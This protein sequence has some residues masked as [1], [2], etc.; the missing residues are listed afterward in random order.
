MGSGRWDASSFAGSTG[1]RLAKGESGYAYSDTVT[2]TKPREEWKVHDTLDPKLENKAGPHAGENVRESCDSDEH[3]NSVPIVVLFDVTGSMRQ[4]PMELV[5]KLPGLFGLLQ[6]KGYVEDPQVLFGAI[7]DATCDQA[8]LQVSQ[9]ES[10][11]RMDDHLTNILLEGGGGAQKTE[12]YE[13]AAY[14]FARKTALDS[15]E[16][17]G[18]KGYLF[19]I[20]DEMPYPQVKT[21]EVLGII[22]DEIEQNISVESIVAELK[23]KYEV[24]FILPFGSGYW[25]DAE[26]LGRWRGLLGAQYVI[27]LRDLSTVAETIAATVGIGEES[28][29]LEQAKK[30]IAEVSD[31][32]VAETVG[33]ALASV[34]G[35]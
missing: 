27:E 7:G 18:K 34:G 17:R 32:D 19:I 29:S 8:P 15:V 30:D 35:A 25:Q 23:E 2:S 4:V 6:M 13:L 1:S 33:S 16:K 21:H 10:D 5:K 14:Y 22:G 26:V 24:F 20:G 9:F 11:N 12:S 3:P 31:A 28:V